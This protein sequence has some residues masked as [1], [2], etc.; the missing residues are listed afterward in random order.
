MRFLQSINEYFNPPTLDV[1][2]VKRRNVSSSPTNVSNI[3]MKI[4]DRYNKLISKE[5]TS[6]SLEDNLGIS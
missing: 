6:E 5:N 3:L 2:P 4:V 1:A